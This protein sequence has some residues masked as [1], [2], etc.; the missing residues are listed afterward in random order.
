MVAGCDGRTVNPRLRKI[1]LIPNPPG[2]GGRDVGFSARF[3]GHS[4]W[5]FGDTFFAEA[6][7]DGYHWR[8]STWSYTDDTD[9]SDGLTGWVHGLGRDGKPAA[10]LPHTAAE[11]AFNGAHNGSPCPARSACGARRTPW[12]GALVADPLRGGA[13]V[14]YSREAAEPTGEFS[15]RSEGSSVATWAAPDGPAVRPA[16][17]PDQPEPTL[18][19]TTAEPPWVEAAAAAVVADGQVYVYG[20]PGGSLTNPCRV[21]RVA[22]AAVLDRGAWRYFTGSG[23]S[24]D[25]RAA[26]PIFDGAPLF[27]VHFSA[28]LKKYVAFYLVPLGTEMAMRTADR[29]EG[30]WSEREIMGKAEAPPS[31]WDYALAA[32]PEFA[33]EGGRIEYLSYVRPGTFLDGTVHL[34][35]VTLP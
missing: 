20:C 33:R 32:H 19:F 34:I 5:I 15:F 35:E 21:A 27:S 28:Y 1:G 25:W 6:S 17:R 13:L 29:P 18:L 31:S 9:A 11:Q 26:A 24:A 7:A 12:P 22:L 23:W 16:V 30:P 4:V 10:L 3:G 2:A 14:F 8:A